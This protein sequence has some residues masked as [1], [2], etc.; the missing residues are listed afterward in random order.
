VRLK[1]L[2]RCGRRARSPK[3]VD[4]PVSRDDLIGVQQ[5][6]RQQCPLFVATEPDRAIP[7]ADLQR[8]E[9]PKIHA[10]F[11]ALPPRIYH[12]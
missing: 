1:G 11:L 7:I 3:I 5:Q 10:P 4:Q 12:R 8:A 2:Q 9:N 6:K